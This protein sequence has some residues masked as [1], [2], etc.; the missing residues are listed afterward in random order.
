[1]GIEA[2]HWLTFF[3]A[4]TERSS[5][6]EALDTLQTFRDRLREEKPDAE[7]SVSDDV[8]HL[9]SILERLLR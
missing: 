6:E 4:F 7:P 9:V 5:T 1:M 8:I 3:Q 2:H